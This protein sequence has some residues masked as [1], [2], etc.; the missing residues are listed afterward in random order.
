VRTRQFAKEVGFQLDVIWNDEDVLELRVFAWNGAFGGVAQVWVG[1][2]D[3]KR[4]LPNSQG[5]Q[6]ILLT[7]V[8]L[9]CVPSDQGV[10]VEQRA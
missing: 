7:H 8:N 2:G 3:W 5:S 1:I 10:Q 6:K 9:S 4:L